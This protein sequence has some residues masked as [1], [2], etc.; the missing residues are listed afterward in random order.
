MKCHICNNELEHLCKPDKETKS[1]HMQCRSPNCP[2]K[3]IVDRCMVSYKNSK[4]TN[5]S[6]WIFEENIWYHIRCENS[7]ITAVKY[8]IENVGTGKYGNTRYGLIA[9]PKQILERNDVGF[10]IYIDDNLLEKTNRLLKR[11]KTIVIFS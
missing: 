6:F 7:K 4:V 1:G 11:I 5:Y 2:R 3:A 10:D 9:E 8:R